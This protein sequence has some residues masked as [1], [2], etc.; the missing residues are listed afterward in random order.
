MQAVGIHPTRGDFSLPGAR[1][2]KPGDPYASTL[3]L[4][5][6][7]FG[8]DRMP[9]LGSERPDE[10][11]L[12]LIARW[13]AGMDGAAGG[14]DGPSLDTPRSAMRLARKLGRGEMDARERDAL[15]AE[16]AKLPSGP[17]RD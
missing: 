8:R 1:I 7:K 6:A 14:P 3:Y 2:I 5:M 4:R 11:G 17:I 16:A 9:R 12:D 10:A 15:L 13:I